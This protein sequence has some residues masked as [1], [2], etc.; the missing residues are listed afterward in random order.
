MK[1]EEL[2]RELAEVQLQKDW[3]ELLKRADILL[4]STLSGT[5]EEAFLLYERGKALMALERFAEARKSLQRS[6]LTTPDQF[7]VH[8]L[9]G[10]CFAAERR[11]LDALWCQ[12]RSSGLYSRF[13][14]SWYEQGRA[15]HELGEDLE[16]VS[17]FRRALDLRPGWL[18]AEQLLASAI[19]RSSLPRDFNE[20][21]ASISQSLSTALAPEWLTRQWCEFA[22]ALFLAGKLGSARLLCE[23]LVALSSKPEAHSL[24]FPHRIAAALLVLVDLAVFDQERLLVSSYPLLRSSLWQP[25]AQAEIDLWYAVVEP[26]LR[27][28][29]QRLRGRSSQVLPVAVRALSALPYAVPQEV[30]RLVSQSPHCALNPNHLTSILSDLSEGFWDTAQLENVPSLLSACQS[31]L[32]R[33][34][35]DGRIRRRLDQ[36]LQTLSNVMLDRPNR[37]VAM[38][39]QLDEALALRIGLLESLFVSDELLIT[40]DEQEAL[41]PT[42]SGLKRFLLVANQDLPQCVLYRVEQKVWQLQRLGCETR[43]I[44]REDLD[45]WQFTRSL[46]WADAVIVCRMPALHPVLRLIHAAKRY[47]CVVFYDIDDLLFDQEHCPPPLISYGGTLSPFMHRRFALDVPLFKSAMQ[48]CDALVFSTTTLARRWKDLHP[49]D[50]KP[51]FVLPNMAPQALHALSSPPADV[52]THGLI[53]VAFASGTTAH[54][55][56]WREELAPALFEL[57]TLNPSLHIDLI[58][59]IEIPDI[60]ASFESR[61]RCK[62]YAEYSSYLRHLGQA[63]I[64]VVVLEPGVYTDAKSAIR[65]MEFSFLGVPSVLSPT[66]V[67]SE[68]LE[69]GRDVLFAR[70]ISE[71]VHTIQRL[72]DDPVLRRTMACNA[73][74]KAQDLFG[75]HRADQYWNSILDAYSRPQRVFKR[76]LLV[77]NVFFAPQSVGGAT[78][79]AQ[80]Q[81]QQLL[82]AAGDRYDV[83]VLCADEH[84]WHDDEALGADFKITVDCHAWKGARVVRL[85]LPGRPWPH[86]IDGSVEE[87]CRQWYKDECFDLIH[88]HSVQVLSAAPLRVARD[89]SIPYIVTLHDG[90]WLSPCLFL[91]TASGRSVEP[92]DPLSHHDDPTAVPQGQLDA[93]QER[94]HDLFSLLES[95]RARL[96]VSRPFADLYLKAGV[97]DVQVL[98]NDWTPMGHPE[99]KRRGSAQPLRLCFVGGMSLH[100]GYAI[101]QA[102]IHQSRLAEC[103]SGACLTVIDS[104]LDAGDDPYILDW[105]GTPV[106]FVSPVAMDMMA[107]FYSCQDVLLAPSIWPESYGLVTR[108]ALS[109]GLWVVASAIGALAEPIQPGVNG[110]VVPPGDPDALSQVLKRLCRE[111]P[112]VAP[113]QDFVATCSAIDRLIPIYD[114]CLS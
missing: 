77:I 33:F 17:C 91:T 22:G 112:L 87:F 60:L 31:H 18:V 26:V 89:M 25:V 2:K 63:D 102:A 29:D 53:R 97:A 92:A 71:W 90:W 37:L 54:K 52:V 114:R 62:P 19:V 106:S 14:D 70:G 16:A 42:A 7:H 49:D 48:A 50:A 9:L 59:S 80:D 44:W 40:L 32:K 10:Y 28:V 51:I 88:A 1:L 45:N 79:V 86:H 96:A 98:E 61:I 57:M 109:A 20:A 84:P 107:E 47:G 65:W 78:R 8:Y 24:G 75:V 69:D 95:A 94:R 6:V 27:I 68:I 36:F 39:G 81:V 11:W 111:H 67:Y 35:R 13:P 41:A 83:T 30:E 4:S 74:A 43:L 56:A 66:A 110:D 21:V 12:R 34:P 76:R 85:S 55:Q 108:E 38:P 103:G 64:G 101:L 99:R 73:Q 23:S 100:K 113:A 93:D 3:T 104:R 82:E 15:A 5:S 105:N 58:G 46:L 72:V